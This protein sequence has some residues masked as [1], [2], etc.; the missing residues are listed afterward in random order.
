M[1]YFE[2]IQ[3]RKLNEKINNLLDFFKDKEVPIFPVKAK[4]I[5]DKYDISEGKLLGN[6]LKKIEEKW[7]NNE[8]NISEEEI[9]NLIKN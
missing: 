8:F 6:K 9:V 2:I 3:S 1:L 7:I 4:N 5:M